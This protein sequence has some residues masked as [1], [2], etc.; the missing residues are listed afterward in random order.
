MPEEAFS[1]LIKKELQ[2]FFANVKAQKQE[3]APEI[4]NFKEACS[5]LSCSG[6][7]LYKL[8]ASR[9]IPHSK[10]G[11]KL[12]FERKKLL[13]WMT[14]NQVDTQQE[15]RVEVSNFFPI[16]NTSQSNP[17]RAFYNWPLI[18]FRIRIFYLRISPA[19]KITDLLS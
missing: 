3:Q 14:E 7:L 17:L 10:R 19:V 13:E 2:A 12:Y 8:T 9:K 5:L 18:V 1:A 4:L 15:I 11:K 16:W 6:S